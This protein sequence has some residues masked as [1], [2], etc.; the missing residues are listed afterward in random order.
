VDH[1]ARHL[2]SRFLH[3]FLGA[4]P[5]LLLYPGGAGAP[6][7]TRLGELAGWGAPSPVFVG[8]HPDYG[9]WFAYRAALLVD[10]NLPVDDVTRLPHPCDACPDKPRLARLAC[11]VGAEHRYSLAQIR[12]HHFHSL[13]TIR[14]YYAT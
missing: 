7:L 5:S 8:I 12:Y 14:S 3:E 2:T 11:P 13:P 1:Y 9:P 6:S 10:L 4:P